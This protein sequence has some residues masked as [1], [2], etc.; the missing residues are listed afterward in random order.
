MIR[1]ESERDQVNVAKVSE[2]GQ[3]QIFEYWDEI[4]ADERSALLAQIDRLDFAEF[5]RLVRTHLTSDD[6]GPEPSQHLAEFEPAPVIAI[7]ETD[8]ERAAYRRAIE[9]GQAALDAGEV[10]ILLV[11]GGQGTRLR[12]DGPKGK[13]PIG[14][15]SERTLFEYHAERILAL[16][17]RHKKAAPWFIMTSDTNHE[18]TLEYFQEHQFFG[19]NSSD[20]YLRPQAM[21][22]IVD[23]RR[24]KILLRSKSELSL[25]PNGH[26]G[27]IA[28]LQSYREVVQKR[29]IKYVFTYQVD[30]P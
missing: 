8:A 29:G 9:V 6:T 12:F 28:L 1:V 20:V 23:P 5:T 30:N 3:E 16:K 10:G 4:G 27:A 19:L 21:L 17:R 18:E 24:G 25:S 13:F 14:P 22:P 26:G 7:P 2:A 11:A 15:I